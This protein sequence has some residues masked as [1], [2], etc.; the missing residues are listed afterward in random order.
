MA[1]ATAMVTATNHSDGDES[2]SGKNP[3][4]AYLGYRAVPAELKYLSS[5]QRNNLK[6]TASQ[7]PNIKR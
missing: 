6:L 2:S 4:E 7:S 5:R 3:L 1:T